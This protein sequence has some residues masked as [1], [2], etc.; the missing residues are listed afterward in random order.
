MVGQSLF[1]LHVSLA[2]S[3]AIFLIFF[4]SDLFL[5][6]S[7]NYVTLSGQ[8]EQSK[9]I[10]LYWG[11]LINNIDLHLLSD[12]YNITLSDTGENDPGGQNSAYGANEEEGSDMGDDNKKR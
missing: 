4:S 6:F 5:W 10:S 7:C 11:K 9:I 8:L 3:Y 2:S 12:F 1:I